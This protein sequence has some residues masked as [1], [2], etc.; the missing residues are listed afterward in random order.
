M[1]G[2]DSEEWATLATAPNQIAAEMWV[3]LLR[4]GGVDARLAPGDEVSFLG[5]SGHP[6]RVL[7]PEAQTA[8]AREVLASVTTAPAEAS[9]DGDGR[10]DD[11]SEES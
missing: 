1:A 2:D 6:C 10:S 5:V 9:D 7:V 8:R 11:E 4:D 3:E